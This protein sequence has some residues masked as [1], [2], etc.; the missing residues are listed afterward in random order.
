[1]VDISNAILTISEPDLTETSYDLTNASYDT[2]SELETVIESDYADLAVTVYTDKINQ[3][4]QFLYP[5]AYQIEEGGAIDITGAQTS[6]ANITVT[7]DTFYIN[8]SNWY[9]Y[10]CDLAKYVIAYKAGY[11]TIPTDLQL[12]CANSVNDAL[13]VQLGETST[14]IK[15]EGVE[16]YNYTLGDTIDMRSIVNNYAASLAFYKRINF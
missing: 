15:S 8:G 4:S 7:G 2:L 16:H 6:G 3:T 13:G 5:R 11:T 14:N 1:M 12:V 10:Y 9:G